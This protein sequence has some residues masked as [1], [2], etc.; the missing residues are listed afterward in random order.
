MRDLEREPRQRDAG[1]LGARSDPVD[2]C[3]FGRAVGVQ[4]ETG[5]SQIGLD[6]FQAQ[7]PESNVMTLARAVINRF[8]KTDVLAAP[9]KIEGAERCRWIGGV[10]YECPD[11]AP[12]TCQTEPIC[13]RPAG[14]LKGGVKLSQRAH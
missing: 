4:P 14:K 2:A 6:M 5:F 3:C 9:K 10:E 1:I 7:S 11:H 13:L 12:G 8:L